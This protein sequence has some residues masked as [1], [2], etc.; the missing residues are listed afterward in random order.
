[1]RAYLD[2]LGTRLGVSGLTVHEAFGRAIA[3]AADLDGLPREIRRLRFAGP[4]LIDPETRSEIDGDA[5]MVLDRLATADQ[6]ARLWHDAGKAPLRADEAEDIA[7]D[8]SALARAIEAFRAGAADSPLRPFLPED[9]VHAQAA[10][11]RA[12]L[13]YV[14]ANPA[15]DA[16]LASALLDPEMRQSAHEVC[17]ARER[18]KA[19]R[20][21]LKELL[22]DPDASDLDEVIEAAA[23]IARTYNGVVD[24]AALS[25]NIETLETRRTA[26]ARQRDL[27]IALPARWAET[28]EQ[29]GTTLADLRLD[30]EML[31]RT[32]DAILDRRQPDSSRA[33]PGLAREAA[34]TQRQLATE[35]T[36]IRKTLP[37]ASEHD[38]ETLNAAADRIESAGLFR[39]LSG[40]F[41]SAWSLYRDDL[42]GDAKATRPA[43]AAAL[44]TYASWSKKRYVFAYDT[45]FSTPLGSVFKG[46]KS[47]PQLL[48]ALAEFH[49]ATDRITQ[50]DERLR[51]AL[52]AGPLEPLR[53]FATDTETP[54]LTLSGVVRALE[55]AETA[56]TAARQDRDAAIAACLSFRNREEIDR[57]MIERATTADAD[58]NDAIV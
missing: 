38:G 47:D 1:M 36:E 42:G 50:G 22:S 43:A 8:L 33:I 54:P 28:A 16:D 24:P 17:N 29:N 40:A 13:D 4:E 56:I 7:N 49:E 53:D 15:C 10:P 31:L 19:A 11:I 37:R 41:K 46:V 3:S 51:Y 27:A 6:I 20:D 21:V 14:A 25:E 32:P 45:R 55:E 23:D 52:E 18:A 2:V 12:A 9:P 44:R 57:D 5:R 39:A 35:L 48:D 58:L 30:I 26:L 34:A